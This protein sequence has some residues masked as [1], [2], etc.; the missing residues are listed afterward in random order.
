[1]AMCR[2]VG[3][4]LED[5]RDMPGFP[6]ETVKAEKPEG[7]AEPQ[8]IPAR[9]APEAERA[10]I[11]TEEATLPQGKRD[12]TTVA[13]LPVEGRPGAA[14]LPGAGKQATVAA[15]TAG[16]AGHGIN[17]GVTA[18]TI[19]TEK[20]SNMPGLSFIANLGRM[21]FGADGAN[22]CLISGGTRLGGI[23]GSARH[24]AD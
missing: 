10:D 3:A 24:R 4:T 17:N 20:S 11:K 19:S 13:G 15:T 14:A 7:P 2:G 8:G 21:S 9:A 6:R 1:M 22:L 23:W 16:L 18:F 5:T 12:T